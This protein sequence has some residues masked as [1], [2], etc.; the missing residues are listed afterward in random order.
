MDNERIKEILQDR[1]DGE[2]YAEIGRK[3][4]LSRQ[5]VQQ[6]L[7]PHAEI[8]NYVIEKYHN[9]CASCGILLNKGGNIHHKNTDYESYND[10]EN[11]EYLC[12]SCHR[13][14]HRSKPNIL[15]KAKIELERTCLNTFELERLRRQIPLMD[16]HNKL[17]KI[18]KDELSKLGYWRNKPRGK[19]RIGYWTSKMKSVHH[20]QGEG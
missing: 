14:K 15:H 19:P 17:Y 6:L 5:W 7:S 10:I 11:L 12:V 9:R 2:S 20:E 1:L 18:L 4:N 16:R 8:R 3:Y 13:R